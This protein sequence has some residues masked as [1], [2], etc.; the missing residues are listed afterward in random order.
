LSFVR[1]LK[2]E[3]TELF[4]CKRT[5]QTCSSLQVCCRKSIKLV[6]N[7]YT[8]F[9]HSKLVQY[10]LRAGEDKLCRTSQ[11]IEVS[12]TLHTSSYSKTPTSREL[13]RLHDSLSIAN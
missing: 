13:V 9:P 11:N 4:V 3:Q 6:D 8:Y 12:R 10:W 2:K 5:K 7:Y 1:L